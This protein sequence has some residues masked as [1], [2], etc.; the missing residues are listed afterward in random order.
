M[1]SKRSR[2]AGW[3]AAGLS[4]PLVLGFGVNPA[5]HAQPTVPGDIGGA[6][7]VHIDEAQPLNSRGQALVAP[8][9]AIKSGADDRWVLKMDFYVENTGGTTLD[10]T[11][12]RVEYTGAGAP[13]AWEEP[14]DVQIDAGDT[15]IVQ[16][17]D[18]FKR[19]LDTPVPASAHVEIEF[20]QI[21]SV[22]AA[23]YSLKEHSNP[24]PH[25]AYFYPARAA[26]LA[27]GEYWSWGARHMGSKPGTTWS[28][29]SRFA[30]DM[31]VGRWDSDDDKWVGYSDDADASNLKN[32][33]YLVWDKPLYAMA[34][35]QVMFCREQ[36]VDHEGGGSGS[37]NVVWIRH[38]SEYAGYVHLKQNSIPS[39][40]CPA[41][42][43]S[44]WGM[45]GNTVTVKAGQEIGRVGNTGNSSA[46]HL[47]LE[48]LADPPPGNPGAN[49]R[50]D[51]VPV[52]FQNALV[53]GDKK[54][55][56]PETDS[57]EW[58]SADGQAI[59][60]DALV[61]PNRCG[62]TPIAAGSPEHARHG[63]SAS[64]YQDVVNRVTAAGYRPVW[65]DGFTVAGKTYF[66]AIFRPV[67]GTPYVAKHGLTDAQFDAEFD[68][69]TAA[70]Y[71][72]L[73]VDGYQH[74]GVARYAAIFVKQAGP[75][76]TETHGLT[77]AENKAKFDELT[78]DGWRPVNISGVS[79][80]GTVRYYA[81]YEKKSL[82]G[83]LAKTT[84]PVADYQELYDAQKALGR[85]PIYLNAFSH[86]GQSYLSAVF[87]STATGT[88][89]AR[90]GMTSAEYQA[91]WE[92]WTD[93][94]FLTRHVTGYDG[95]GT[96][97]YA[98]IWRP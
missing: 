22:L 67:D 71:R 18:G 77:F 40:I 23:D 11:K 80:A 60:W 75:E 30:Y 17:L 88:L 78:A 83:Y 70:G 10:A 62:F 39:N 76:Q 1:A 26:D 63:I 90:H 74:G 69:W 87:S 37:A 98:A 8:L 73:Q 89:A 27:P 9:T 36:L 7:P 54:D 3:V 50:A 84:I 66:N 42:M 33:D 41:G 56:N 52:T 43:D 95:G 13:A 4:V 94:D 35:G 57:F 58:T 59:G 53:R 79:D 81:L 34:D 64:C 49:P 29:R 92:K 82:G 2:V 31:G 61:L 20:A 86:A 97:R 15:E 14:V 65:V 25:G 38:G 55:L 47:H 85:Q 91:E 45:N 48:V 21:D 24:V 16:L 28:D 6:L 5:A 68:K 72:M 32:A 44:S 96:A 46:P 12:V 51:G 93:A 19:N